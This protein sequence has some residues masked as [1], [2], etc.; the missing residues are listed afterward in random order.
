MQVVYCFPHI[1]FLAATCIYMK[2]CFRFLFLFIYLILLFNWCYLFDCKIDAA[3]L[4]V[5]IVT[6]LYTHA[7]SKS[8][9]TLTQ[10][11]LKC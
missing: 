3:R 5:I 1:K 6:I 2:K 4:V 8:S 7:C 10:V 11:W 9:L